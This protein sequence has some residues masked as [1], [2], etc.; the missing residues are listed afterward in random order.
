M[1]NEI[2]YNQN[3]KLMDDVSNIIESSQRYAYH[4]VDSILVL[5]NWLLGK[6]IATENMGGTGS[7]RYGAEIIAT[8]SENLTEKYGKGF[9]K[10]SLYHYVKFYQNFP[11]I[12]ATMSPQSIE[13]QTEEIVAT[14]SPQ[15][16]DVSKVGMRGGLLSWSHYRVL[17]HVEGS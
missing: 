6:R 13:G 2:I 11:E 1:N 7:E 15:S 17:L 4:A 12:V 8:L 10:S 9:D 3:G 16:F 14:V 5:R